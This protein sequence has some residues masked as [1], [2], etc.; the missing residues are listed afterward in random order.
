MKSRRPLTIGNLYR[1]ETTMRFPSLDLDCSGYYG[2]GE[3]C[4]DVIF[5]SR[6][7]R[8][9]FELLVTAGKKHF[10]AAV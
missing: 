8:P 7:I 9:Y 3:P 10:P 5:I 6:D 1:L 2:G 4:S